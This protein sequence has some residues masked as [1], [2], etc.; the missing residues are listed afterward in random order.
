MN[1]ELNENTNAQAANGS[2]SEEKKK[3]GRPSKEENAVKVKDHRLSVYINNEIYDFWME[4]N[5]KTKSTMAA[6]IN[7]LLYEEMERL[8]K[9]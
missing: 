8:K 5:S 4:R 7:T 1:N 2:G 9:G 6:V 3:P